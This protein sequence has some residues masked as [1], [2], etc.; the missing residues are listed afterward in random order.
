MRGWYWRG[1]LV[2]VSRSAPSAT[3]AEEANWIAIDDPK[4]IEYL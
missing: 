1:W 2:D 3:N 4:R